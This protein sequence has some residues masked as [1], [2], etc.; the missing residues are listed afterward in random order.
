MI[1]IP[2]G[3]LEVLPHTP[4]RYLP[5]PPQSGWFH[6]FAA[7]GRDGYLPTPLSASRLRRDRYLPTNLLGIPIIHTPHLNEILVKKNTHGVQL[8]GRK[9]KVVAPGG[10][11]GHHRTIRDLLA[12]HSPKRNHRMYNLCAGPLIQ[13]ILLQTNDAHHRE[14]R[15]VTTT[16]F[17]TVQAV[18]YTHLTLP[19][20][21]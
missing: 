10:A 9:G 16:K 20:K 13:P 1:G 6:A 19:T 17:A 8:Y 3:V 7:S 14:L 11:A 12:D 15:F 21:A 18:S 5:T 4:E 2:V